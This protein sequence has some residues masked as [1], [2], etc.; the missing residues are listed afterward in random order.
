MKF[1][2]I[3]EIKVDLIN[4]R[5]QYDVLQRELQELQAACK[6]DAPKTVKTHMS[7]GYIEKFSTC[8]LCDTVFNVPCCHECGKEVDSGNVCNDHKGFD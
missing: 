5:H 6:H 2:T 8:P 7:A 3:Q 4:A 1:R